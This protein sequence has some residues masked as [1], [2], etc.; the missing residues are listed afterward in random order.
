MFRLEESLHNTPPKGNTAHEAFLEVGPSSDRGV[1]TP[2]E[3]EIIYSEYGGCTI[4]FY[5][6]T[7]SVWGIWLPFNSFEVEFLNHLMVSPLQMHRASYAYVKFFSNGA[8]M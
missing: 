7:F 4:I 6:C 8:N 2:S 1:L 3:N 5:K